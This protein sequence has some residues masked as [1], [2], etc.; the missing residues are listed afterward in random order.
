MRLLPGVDLSSISK[1]LSL[2]DFKGLG[3][4]GRSCRG[5]TVSEELLHGRDS[6]TK[7]PESTTCESC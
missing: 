6:S 5:V 3:I 7:N 1:N 2:S 4:F